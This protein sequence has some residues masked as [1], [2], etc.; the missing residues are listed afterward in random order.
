MPFICIGPVCIPWS[1]VWPVLLFLLRPIWDRLPS[2]WQEKLTAMYENFMK[3]LTPRWNG[4]PL[5]KFMRIKVPKRNTDTQ[6]GDADDKDDAFHV[7]LRERLQSPTGGL[8]AVE[9]LR[10]WDALKDHT[11]KAG[12]GVLLV[13]GAEWCKPCKQIAPLVDTLSF[14]HATRLLTAKVDVEVGEDVA[15]ECGA[16]TLPFFQ[17]WEDGAMV[18]SM[19]GA[20]EDQLKDMVAEFANR[21]KT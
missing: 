21:K 20:R 7:L 10:E 16:S 5:P 13:F 12:M 2:A 3:W 19:T 14:E 4:L 18:T 8:L 17:L 15:D 6:C 11:S 9:S 1:F